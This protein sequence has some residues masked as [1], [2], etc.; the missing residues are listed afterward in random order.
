MLLNTPN[1]WRKPN[2]STTCCLVDFAFVPHRF[3]HRHEGSPQAQTPAY[4]LSDP[5][6]SDAEFA[7]EVHYEPPKKKSYKQQGQEFAAVFSTPTKTTVKLSTPALPEFTA[8]RAL[9]QHLFIA[10]P[11]RLLLS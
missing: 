8:L 6:E 5:L 3:Q 1:I 10:K 11:P 9:P 4:E 7:G 2:A